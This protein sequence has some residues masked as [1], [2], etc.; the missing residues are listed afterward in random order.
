MHHRLQCKRELGGTDDVSLAVK[1]LSKAQAGTASEM[2][3]TFFA[4]FATFFAQSLFS[5]VKSHVL[6][7]FRRFC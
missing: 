5:S 4:E 6:L 1:G 2:R 7:V 3:L